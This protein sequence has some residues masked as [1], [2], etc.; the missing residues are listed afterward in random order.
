VITED[1]ERQLSS[2]P[3]SIPPSSRLRPSPA[4]RYIHPR[5]LANPAEE[6]KHAHQ[7]DVADDSS[8]NYKRWIAELIDPHLGHRVL[9]LGAGTGAVTRLYADGREVVAVDLSTECVTSMRQRFAANPNISVVQGDLRQLNA[10]ED[11]F[12]SVLMVNVLEHMQNDDEVLARLPSVLVPGGRIVIY[13]PA[14]NGL[15]GK[16][17]RQVGH[18]RRY[19]KWRLREVAKVAGLELI[20]LRYVNALAIP[21]WF[22][23]SHTEVDRTQGG[24][25]SI[26]DRTGVLL[27]RALERRIPPPIGL[28]LLGV[29][30]AR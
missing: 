19:S 2:R 21:A 12:D 11:R 8:P 17:D 14:L 5:A 16:W 24:G 6:G 18:F 4:A 10:P 9:E 22:A 25:L 29:L 3:V 30:V 1:A 13:V 28:N 15:Y 20:E 23:F 26:W 27:T 7:L